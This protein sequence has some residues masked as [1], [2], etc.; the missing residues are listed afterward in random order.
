MANWLSAIGAAD[1]L[2]IEGKFQA[3]AKGEQDIAEQ[4][5]RMEQSAELHPLKKQQMEIEANKAEIALREAQHAEEMGN[6]YVSMD[7]VVG[8]PK[9]APATT[10]RVMD[11]YK[12]NG[13]VEFIPGAGGQ[14]VASIKMK[15]IPYG[16]KMMEND[17][18]FQQQLIT[19]RLTDVE[20]EIVQVEQQKAE[21]AGKKGKN[22]QEQM[23]QLEAKSKALA[24]QKSSLLTTSAQLQ[25]KGV[26][27]EEKRMQDATTRRGQDLNYRANV[28]RIGVEREKNER[29]IIDK[30]EGRINQLA[31]VKQRLLTGDKNDPLVA[32]ILGQTPGDDAAK[33]GAIKAAIAEIDNEIGG[34]Y[35]RHKKY[36]GPRPKEIKEPAISN[37][38]KLMQR[39]NK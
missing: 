17:R 22:T 21:L 32:A 34:I 9:Q 5:Q 33:Q 3:L 2:A 37:T 36:L 27:L 14:D 23:L 25:G 24:A 18:A 7:M 6:K 11:F 30:A 29:E 10:K 28:E 31:G 16:I 1:P 8:D 15:N 39:Y 35:D 12:N 20:G 38:Q 4:K 13:L 26:E 19:D